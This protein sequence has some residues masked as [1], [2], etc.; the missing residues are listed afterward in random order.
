MKDE[1]QEATTPPRDDRVVPN[2]M[3]EGVHPGP[4]EP[5]A[6]VMY[7]PERKGTVERLFSS[8]RSTTLA[9]LPGTA[10][11]TVERKLDRHYFRFWG[12]RYGFLVP[13][14]PL[15]TVPGRTVSIRF[16]PQDIGTVRVLDPATGRFLD[17]RP[18]GASAQ[19]YARGRSLDEHL[20]LREA[21]RERQ[22]S[23]SAEWATTVAVAR[24]RIRIIAASAIRQTRPHDT[25]RRAGTARACLTDG[26]CR[27]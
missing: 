25:A 26:Y 15:G 6:G 8:L 11:K 10:L 3:P 17:A 12:L 14:R 27:K 16:D 4:D 22:L 23:A 21:A 19:A 7:R 9:P 1:I 18:V 24:E 2:R 13:D 5:R 20:A